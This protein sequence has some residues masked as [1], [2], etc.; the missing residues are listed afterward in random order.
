MKRQSEKGE[1]EGEI[2]AK[3]ESDY[4]DRQDLDPVCGEWGRRFYTELALQRREDRFV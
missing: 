2:S 1:E 3:K 4:H